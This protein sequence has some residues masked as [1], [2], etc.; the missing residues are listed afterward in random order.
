MELPRK[1]ENQKKK[2]FHFTFICQS[3]ISFALPMDWT[4]ENM[5]CWY[6]LQKNLTPQ[7]D[8]RNLLRSENRSTLTMT[9]SWPRMPEEKRQRWNATSV[10][11]KKRSIDKGIAAM[12]P[13]KICHLLKYL[14]CKNISHEI[15]SCMK[16]SGEI[17]SCHH[18][19]RLTRPS[20]C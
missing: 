18:P 2:N 13:I 19:K 9:C 3:T 10:T 1:V 12:S 15:Y 17:D 16:I 4:N 5:T 6:S 7:D 14:G 8:C 11:K 20:V